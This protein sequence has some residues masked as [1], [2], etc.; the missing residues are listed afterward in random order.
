MNNLKK[1]Y[2]K[3]EDESHVHWILRLLVNIILVSYCIFHLYTGCFGILGGI[4]QRIVHLAF[5][6]VLTF[7]LY[8]TTKQNNTKAKKII[9]DLISFLLIIGSLFSSIYIFIQ[10]STTL[11]GRH[12]IVYFGDV[13]FGIIMIIAILEGTRRI[14]GKALPSISL[15]LLLYAYL[16]RYMPSIVAHQ[17]FNVEGIVNIVYLTTEG[18]YGIAIYVS[19]TFIFLFIILA[20]LLEETG[21]G[22]FFIDFAYKIVGRVRGGPAKIA[23]IASSFFGMFSGSAL[24]NVASTGSFTIPLMKKVGYPPYYAAAVEAVASTGGQFMPPIMASASFIIAEI[25]GI[26]YYKVM[27]S[28]AIPAFLYYVC[29]FFQIDFFA[30]KAGLV[31]VS[32]KEANKISWKS[33]NTRAYLLF[34]VGVLFYTL[35]VL[36]YTTSKAAIWTI[37]STVAIS[38]LNKN[39]RLNIF[40]LVCAFKKAG[41]N[42]V[43]IALC[44]ANIGIIVGVLML[45]GMGLKLSSLLV[46]LAHGNLL[47]LL[48]L[49]MIAS[50]IL[51]MGVP[52][53]AAYL[54]LAL[55]V[56]PALIQMG[57]LPL[58]AHLFIFYFGIISCITPP[59]AMAAYVAAG[60]AGSNPTKTGFMAWKLGLTAFIVPFVMVYNPGLLGIGSFIQI[61]RAIIFAL[62]SVYALASSLEGYLLF[63]KVNFFPWRILLIVVVATVIFPNNMMINL[64]GIILFIGI[65]AIHLIQMILQKKLEQT[66]S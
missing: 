44:C 33:L 48:V 65:M 4:K 12:G 15:I 57:V 3:N 46:T 30:A 53:L 25:L 34:P 2:Q 35:A 20:A 55:V 41:K 64:F 63:K 26:P 47:Y 17:G 7:T 54:L 18:I 50:I 51:G 31:G 58:A 29:L 28:A 9:S 32:K 5:A 36:R 56:G 38:A 16:G 8:P 14:V 27:L 43:V 39:S 22:Q 1:L 42:I 40:K 59:V 45:T 11:S 60:I 10:D 23:V 21:M 62:I 24:A 6:L 37:L 13:V 66:G 52:T 61:F 19:A 49:T